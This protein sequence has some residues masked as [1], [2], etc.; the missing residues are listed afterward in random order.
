MGREA[1]A[2]DPD[3]VRRVVAAVLADELGRLRGRPVAAAERALWT[4]DTPVDEDGIGADSL[5]R[6][7]LAARVD[8]AFRLGDSGVEDFLLLERSLGG[9]TEVVREGLRRGRG[10]VTFRTSGST[11]TPKRVTHDLDDLAAESHGHERV[12]PPAERI[13]VLAPTHH[14]YGFLFGALGPCLYGRAVEDATAANPA[15]LLRRLAPGDRVIAT[16]MHWSLALDADADARAPAAAHGVT[17]TAP[18]PRAVRAAAEARGL[19]PFVEIYGSTETAGLGWRDGASDRF[20]PL[21]HLEGTDDPDAPFRRRRDGA[22]LSPPDRVAC[23]PDGSFTVGPRLD[24]AVQ[25]GGVNVHPARVR[26][27]LVAHPDVADCAVRLEADRADARLKAFVIP[28]GDRAPAPEVLD[29]WCAERLSPPE[30]PLR[31]T[32][33]PDLPRDPLGKPAD[34]P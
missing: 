23:H 7:R 20:R 31:F 14:V 9:W 22:A 5:A 18:C 26:E 2:A 25:V 34:W 13:V 10:R 16:P 21:P 30:R 3:A 11:G 6:L 4:R 8:E 12:L 17:S 28:A 32:F 1:L 29:R 27:I 33:G 24:A 15:A 19:A